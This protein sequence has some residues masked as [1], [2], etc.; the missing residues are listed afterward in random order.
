MIQQLWSELLQRWATYAER[1]PAPCPPLYTGREVAINRLIEDSREVQQG[2]CF[3][4]RVRPYSDGHPYIPQAIARGASLIIAQHPPA[5]PIPDDVL[6]VQVEDTAIVESWL[7]AAWHNFPAQALQLIGVTGTDG[8]TTITNLIYEILVAAGCRTGMISTIKA[9]IGDE[10]ESTGLHVTT[11]QAPQIQALLRRMVDSG[12][13]HCVL[14]ITSMGLAEHR[15]DTAF[16]DI[17]AISNVTHEHLDYHGSWEQY[18]AHKARLFALAE[19]GVANLDDLSFTSLQQIRPNLLSYSATNHS[20]DFTAH[21]IS[22]APSGTKFDLQLPTGERYTIATPLVGRFN[23]ANMLCAAAV[24]YLLELP[25]T[26]VQE[27]LARVPQISGRMERIDEGQ[28]FLVIVDFAHTPNALL[29]AI[30]AG[31]SMT[32]GR[33][34]TVFGSAGRRDVEKRRMM[35]EVSAEYADLTILTA[36][37]PRNEPLD[38]ILQTMAEGAISKGGREGENFWRIPDR[39]R[40][41]YHG[42]SLATDSADLLLICGKGHEQSICFGSTEYAWDD[43]TATRATL[44]AFLAN[45]PPP[46]LGLPT[47][48]N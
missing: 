34:I 14:E 1:H 27:G 10:E 31:R 3:I 15:A 22:F 9:V 37:D 41:I 35:A 7:A 4:A 46:D 26:A 38:Q 21:S 36:E 16:F 23:I 33:I 8:K 28:H 48:A 40:A 11:P 29:K 32:A 6:Y 17:A 5:T 43:R 19:R 47:F 12:L 30:E 20:A 25:V 39:G 13:T 45:N 42:L 24:A 2:D 44:R 18:L